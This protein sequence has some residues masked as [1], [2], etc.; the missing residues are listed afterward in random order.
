MS[1]GLVRG[2]DRVAV[3]RLSLFLSVPVLGAAGLLQ[4]ATEPRLDLLGDRVVGHAGGPD[5]PRKKLEVLNRIADE[6]CPGVYCLRN[7]V[8][9]TTHLAA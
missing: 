6:H 4:V 8:A 1:A 9:L 2:L 7:P 5:A 3:T